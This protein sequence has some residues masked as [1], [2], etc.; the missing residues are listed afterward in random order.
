MGPFLRPGHSLLFAALVPLLGLAR[1]ARAGQPTPV[2]SPSPLTAQPSVPIPGPST[3]PSLGQA[4]KPS[5]AEQ[6]ALADHLRQ[7]G[8][9]FYGAYWCTHCFRQK[10]LFGQQAGNRLPYV[11]CAKDQAGAD[12][13]N[14]AGVE[15]YPTWVHGKQRLEGVQSLE[16]LAIWS[17]FAGFGNS[18]GQSQGLPASANTLKLPSPSRTTASPGTP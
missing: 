6:L 14:A 16:E 1:P 17:G 8:A 3:T 4:L 5:T 7:Q 13:C 12:K 9:I 10:N 2:P 18:A 15:A 11:E